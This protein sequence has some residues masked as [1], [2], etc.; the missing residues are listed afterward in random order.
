VTHYDTVVSQRRLPNTFRSLRHRNF[1]L[2]WLSQ[3][4]SLSGTW[5]QA[6]AKGWLILR[7]TNSPFA[8]GYI[9]FIGMLPALPAALIG[10]AIIDRLPKRKLIL[11]T[12]TGLLLQ[13]LA[14]AALAASGQIQVWHLILLECVWGTLGA[15]DLPARQSFV[16]EMVGPDDLTNAIALNASVFN[17]ARAF[18]PAIGGLL[19]GWVGEAGCF[20][21]N[22]LTFLAVIG[23]LLLMRIEDRAAERDRK[24]IGR[25]MI[26]GFGYVLR[27]PLILGL[28]SLMAVT[29]LFGTPYINLMPVFARDVLVVGERGLGFLMAAVGVGAMLGALGVANMRHGHR[30]RWLVTGSMIFPIMLIAFA[31]L[32]QFGPA[33]IVLVLAGTAFIMQQSLV[34]T[35]L[36][37][38]VDDRMRGRIM[39]LYGLLFIGVQQAGNLVAGGAAQLWGAPITVAAGAMICMVFAAGLFVRSP[40]IR[41]LE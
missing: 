19:L 38:I 22:G 37:L 1:R 40:T 17:A 28:L 26:D 34:N 36:Q 7:I 35:L 25:S 27:Q 13:A 3:I 20:F 39:S 21:I 15:I 33:L 11:I 12:Q 4:L 30:G 2:F 24:A 29:G 6:V 10:G 14:L 9:T 5:M 18:G 31:A 16:I 41:R 23:G 32:P 8:L